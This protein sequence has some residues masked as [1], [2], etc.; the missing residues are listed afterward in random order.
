MLGA[1][2][3]VSFVSLP[4]ADAQAPSAPAA[5]QAGAPKSATAKGELKSVDAVKKTLTLTAEN[6]VSQTFLYTDTT[7]V[8]GAQG[9]GVEGLATMSRRLVTVQYTTKGVDRIASSIEVAVKQ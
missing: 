4:I 3:L 1:F 7:E 8:S 5:A 6:G 2:A 9:G